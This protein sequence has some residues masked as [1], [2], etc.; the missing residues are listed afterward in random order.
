MCGLFGFSG[1]PKIFDKQVAKTVQAKVKILGLYN[2]ERG[3]HSCGLFMNNTVMKGVGDDKLFNDFIQNNQLPDAIDSG[4]FTI[5]GHTRQA[6]HGEHTA[7]NAHPFMIDR[8]L[9][10]A[11][12]GVIRNIW[13]LCNK[14]KINHAQIRVDSLGLAHLIHAN[15]FSILN[16]YEGFAAL[17]MA[18]ASEPNSLYMYRGVSK[19]TSTGEEMEERPL[20]YMQSEEGIYVSSLEKSL[21][22]ISDSSSDRIKQVE[23]NIVHKLT[24][25]KMTKSKFHVNR[26]TINIGVSTT[27]AYTS[28]PNYAKQAGAGTGTQTTT[29]TVGVK[30]PTPATISTPTDATNSKVGT[31]TPSPLN[32]D[33][34]VVP[35]IWHETLPS[36]VD[37][38]VACTGV[39]YQYGRF[40]LVDNDEIKPAHGEH[41][42][43]KKGRV[44]THK[45]KD[46][47]NYYF[48]EGVMMRNEKCYKA[49]LADEDL[50]NP[51]YNFAM[52]ISK[53]SEFPVCNSRSD[54]H[55]RNKGVSN[56]CKY[57]WY[58]NGNMLSNLG[59]TPKFSD[60][61]YI[62]RDGLTNSIKSQPSYA[63]IK[64]EDEC[65]DLISLKA[66]RNRIEGDSTPVVPPISTQAPVVQMPKLPF[67]EEDVK[68]KPIEEDVT[69]FY[70]VWDSL[71]QARS[72]FTELE[73]NALRYYVCDVMMHEMEIV[74]DTIH[75]DTVDVQLNMFLHMCIE[76]LCSTKDMW[77]E[78]NYQD[79]IHY[80]S[81]ARENPAGEFKGDDAP[82]DA[83]SEVCEFVPKPVET[84]RTMMLNE[85]EIT[86]DNVNDVF[87]DCLDNEPPV[88]D[89]AIQREQASVP[90]VD[91]M[92]DISDEELYVEEVTTDDEKRY[93]FE[94]I[95]DYAGTIRE[96]ADELTSREDDNF[97]Q[98]VASL[99]YRTV[100]PMLHRLRELCDEHN[101][102]EL[103]KHISEKIKKQVGI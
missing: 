67:K 24:N 46:N 48:Y 13:Q 66:E 103:G 33:K 97:S 22:A 1:D 85:V 45:H 95:V 77:D 86:V 79:I 82:K 71:E 98:E 18:K 91:A 64:K 43:N 58:L 34:P 70:R 50:K 94:D 74:P 75:D 19:R 99:V 57:R 87:P 7:E 52:M 16:E 28:G 36:R 26:D 88:I 9:I 42:I 2:I 44:Y 5:I 37:R 59:F 20:Y 81:I 93:A 40:W 55:T 63:N 76:N 30:N 21:L 15:G 12:N 23:G 100:D 61:N 96:A 68:P 8:S 78:A 31:T 65:V 3:K 62:L 11:H 92:T 60:R 17:L 69:N 101:E 47:G 49:A 41:Y 73:I 72:T 51:Q 83:C 56:Y 53:Y 35:M 39:F 89:M 10:L 38:Y 90:V 32:F 25:G 6:T 84:V 80:L 14:Y 102:T 27:T 54:V 29:S 4:I